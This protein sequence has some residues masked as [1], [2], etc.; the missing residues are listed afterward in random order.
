MLKR[1]IGKKRHAEVVIEIAFGNSYIV[2]N[3]ITTY[4]L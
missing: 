3:I 4:L 1:I 2:G